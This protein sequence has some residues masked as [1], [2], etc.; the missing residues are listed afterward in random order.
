M[1][2]QPKKVKQSYAKFKKAMD[3]IAKWAE[4]RKFKSIYGPCRGGW[5]PAVALSHL[6][7]IPIAQTIDGI[8]EDTLIIEDI[9]DKG[10]TIKKVFRKIRKCKKMKTMPKVAAIFFNKKES[11]F[12]PDYF[13]HEKKGWVQFHYETDKSSKYDKTAIV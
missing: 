13:V 10:E 11:C 8:T 5:T 1:K 2:K 7:D 6:L 3:K 12:T 9:I 4:P